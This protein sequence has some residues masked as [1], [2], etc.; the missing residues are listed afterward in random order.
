LIRRSGAAILPNLTG[1]VIKVMKNYVLSFIAATVFSV[2]ATPT[3]VLAQSGFAPN[4]R[5]PFGNSNATVGGTIGAGGDAL[6]NIAPSGSNEILRHRDFTGRAC[7]VVNAFARPHT[8]NPNL[9]DHVIDV[10]NVCPQR[11]AMQVCYYQTQDCIAID[12]PGDD[13]KEAILGTMPSER[14]FRYEF[15]EKFPSQN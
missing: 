13:R 12:V 9:Y 14:D 15:R 2:V 4:A 3:F 5:T 6:P 8:V 1:E 7:L 11:I 10:R